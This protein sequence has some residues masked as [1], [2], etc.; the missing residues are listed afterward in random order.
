MKKWWKAI[1]DAREPDMRVPGYLERWEL[2]RTPRDERVYLHRIL[3]PDERVFHDHPWSF[4]TELLSGW[5]EQAWAH[6]SG[7]ARDRWSTRTIMSGSSVQS[8][9]VM[10]ERDFHYIRKVGQREECW[11]L[12]TTGPR[13]KSWGFWDDGRYWPY[14]EYF[15]AH[16]EHPKSYFRPGYS[17]AA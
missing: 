12:V 17:P 15:D 9:N 6:A 2:A 8:T 3:G 11:S 14:Q 1:E 10:E 16:P 13:V 7:I 5:Y 4:R